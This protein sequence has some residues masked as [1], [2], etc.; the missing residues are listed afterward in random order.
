M[1]LSEKIFSEYNGL[2]YYKLHFETQVKNDITYEQYCEIMELIE[3][4]LFNI[5]ND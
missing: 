1:I 3:N 5:K 2:I 4:Y